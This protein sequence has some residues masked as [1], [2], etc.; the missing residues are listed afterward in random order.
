MARESKGQQVKTFKHWEPGS[1]AKTVAVIKKVYFKADTGNFSIELPDWITAVAP[2]FDDVKRHN[3]H[4]NDGTW[5]DVRRTPGV[6][7]SKTQDGCIALYKSVCASFIRFMRL[8]GAV[9]RIEVT[10]KKNVPY[11]PDRAHSFNGGSVAVGGGFGTDISFCGSPALHMNYRVVWEMNG[12]LFLKEEHTYKGETTFTMRDI[13]GVDDPRSNG[14]PSRERVIIPWTQE[15][16]DFLAGIVAKITDLAW[17]LSD[18]LGDA[19][20]NITHALTAGGGLLAIAPPKADAG[21]ATLSQQDT[22]REAGR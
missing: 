18:F 1:D 10:F 15:R 8:E 21:R 3:E 12:R 16:E 2:G 7:Y 13:G 6:I 14:K 5:A 4:M 22:T 11:R 20:A 9:K 17:L 19:E